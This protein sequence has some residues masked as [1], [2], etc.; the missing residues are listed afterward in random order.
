MLVPSQRLLRISLAIFLPLLAVAGFSRA[1]AAPCGALM[2]L[3]VL[4][5]TVDAWAG[6]HRVQQ[7]GAGTPAYLRLTKDVPSALPLT[8]QNG[9]GAERKVRVG[10]VMPEGMESEK[11]VL[12]PKLPPGSALLQWNCTGRARGDH[13][14]RRIYIEAV[15]PL[16]L[17]EARAAKAVDCM[18]RVYPEH[19]RPRHRGPVS[20]DRQPGRPHVPAGGQGP[21]V[22]A[23]APL[24]FR[25][26]LRRHSLEGH[27][28]ARVS[29]GEAVPRGTCAGSV[30]RDRF[31]APVR[32]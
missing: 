22:R 25:R 5:A 7:I 10:M 2:G 13:P 29:H 26:Q 31:F 14:L 8:L 12:D 20:E 17:W 3:C 28:Q 6:W 11:P 15:S 18:F 30:C 16:G 32:P 19:A 24:P 27:R 23:V 21:R 9:S 4:A 1:L